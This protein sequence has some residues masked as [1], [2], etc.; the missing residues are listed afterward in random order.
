M[1]MYVIYIYLC[2]MYIFMLAIFAEVSLVAAVSL[3]FLRS[4]SE[5]HLRPKGI[6]RF[7]GNSSDF[8]GGFMG[9]N[10]RI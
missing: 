10:N 1:Y 3:I 5:E 8:P 4:L 6:Q 9:F 7:S 2:I